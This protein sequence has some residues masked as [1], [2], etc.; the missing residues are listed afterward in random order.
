MPQKSKNYPAQRALASIRPET[1]NKEERTVEIVFTTGEAGERYD[2]WTGERYIEELDVSEKAVRSARLDKGLSVIDSHNRWAGIGGVLGVTEGWRI[3]SGQLVGTAR[4]SKKHQDVF[5]DVEDGILRHVSLGYRIHEWEIK[6]GKDEPELRKAVDWEPLEL[7]I[8]PIS[9]ETTNGMRS[10]DSGKEETFPVKM[11]NNEV[12]EMPLPKKKVQADDDKVRSESE[13]PVV[14]GPVKKEEEPVVTEG[15]RKSLPSY[16]DAARAAGLKDDFAIDAYVRGENID[17]FRANV[18]RELADTNSAEKVRSF[19]S[20]P[21]LNSDGRRDEGESAVRSAKEF[22]LYRANARGAELTDGA[23]DFSGMSM[24]EMARELLERSGTRTRGMSVRAIAERAFHSTSDFPLILE[25]VINKNLL[26]AFQETPRTF[27]GLG[28]RTTVNDFKDK[29]TYRLG[30]APDLLPLN[31]HG[32]YKSGTFSESG[33]RFAIDTFA[34]KIGFTRKMLINDDMNALERVPSMFGQAG[35]RLENDIVWGLILNYD[36]IKNK[37][38]DVRMSDGKPLFHADHGNLATAGSALSKASLNAAR[39]AGRKQKTLDKKFMNVSF[40]AM[41][42]SEDLEGDAEDLL[43]PSILAAKIED[44]APR[45]KM[46][47][48]VEPR[49]GVVSPAA[50]YLFSRMIDTFEYAYLL[51]ED[52]M[53]TETVMH[54][55]I[56]GM[57]IKVRKDFGAGLVDWRGFYKATGAK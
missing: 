26:D 4:F 51:G 47:L 54:T 13:V 17:D 53:Y 21:G 35:A 22:L 56:D 16:L 8:V 23:K 10:A 37:A 50:W 19:A 9:F 48:I 32:Q 1:I 25:D 29:H 43:F 42:V 24:I 2:W 27:L 44:Q 31:E 36:F 45:T 12:R 20:D 11:T 55:D 46:N 38:A 6:K 49:L 7:S 30:D 14:T 33:E 28:R 52:E 57:E 39:A 41:V 34:R 15:D 3:E 40:G 18:L 5:D